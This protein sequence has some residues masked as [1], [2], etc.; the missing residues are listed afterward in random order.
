MF[1]LPASTADAL[2]VSTAALLTHSMQHVCLLCVI[3][4][5]RLSA[6][7]LPLSCLALHL[8][9][10]THPACVG[11]VL[12]G[13]RRKGRLDGG[14]GRDGPTKWGDHDCGSIV[15]HPWPAEKAKV[16]CSLA[17]S[18]HRLLQYSGA[19]RLLWQQWRE[20]CCEAEVNDVG[21]HTRSTGLHMMQP[22][23]IKRTV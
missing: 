9:S 4:L 11:G 7:C 19:E 14:G 18:C 20:D 1:K 15:V 13:S 10:A 22:W 2:Q 16:M 8:S 21:L 23:R 6:T 12:W 17:A 3:H 5:Y